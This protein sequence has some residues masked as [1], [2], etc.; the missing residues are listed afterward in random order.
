MEENYKKYSKLVFNYL[1]SL[2]NN[3]ELAEELTQ[4]TFYRAIKGINSFR[5]ECS[6]G[7]WF[8]QIAKNQW[9]NY[10]KKEKR[11]KIVSIEDSIDEIDIEKDIIDHIYSKDQIIDVYKQ[12]HQL[13]SDTKEVFYLRL[14]GE[15][16]FKDIGRILGKTEEWARV[17]FFR[18]KI[19]IKEEFKNYE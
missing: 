12:I 9:K 17:T 5:N 10:L 19:K 2:T 14:K 18:G 6:I 3:K 11:K 16:T 8:C 4:E 15:L 1:Y 13:D 7:V